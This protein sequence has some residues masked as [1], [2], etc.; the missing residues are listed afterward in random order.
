M[1]RKKNP[2]TNET[3]Q[4]NAEEVKSTSAGKS[5]KKTASKSSSSGKNRKKSVPKT[6]SGKAADQ[7]E[8]AAADVQAAAGQVKADVQDMAEQVK[9]D[10]QDMAEQ[11]KTDVQDAAEQVKTDVQ[12]AAEQTTT[13][14]QGEAAESEAEAKDEAAESEAEVKGEAAE[15]EAEA[16]DE[17]EEPEAEAKDET[18]EPEAEAKDETAEPEAEAQ[19]ETAEKQE[20]S[21]EPEADKEETAEKAAVNVKD[22]AR[23]L[24]TDVRDSVTQVGDDL[25]QIGDGIKAKGKEITDNAK[26][27]RKMFS[28]GVK[29]KTGQV[30]SGAVQF[31]ESAIGMSSDL[32]GLLTKEINEMKHREKRRSAEMISIFAKHNFYAG[33]FTPEEL[34]TTLEDLGPTYVKIGQIM[35]SRVDMLPESY[36]KELEKLRQNVKPLDSSVVRAI[37]EQETGKKIEEIYSFFDDNPLGSAS[38]GQ[39]HKATLLDGTQVVTKVQRP[40]IADMMRKDFVLLKKL[41]SVVK[42]INEGNEDQGEQIDLLAVLEELEKVEDEELDFRVEARNTIFFRENC[43]DDETKVTCPMIY[44]DLTTERMMTSTFIDGYSVSKKEKIAADGFDVNVIGEALLDNY[45]HQVLDVGVFHGDPHQGNIM[46]NRQ[47]VP[48]WIDFGMIGRLSEANIKMIQDLILSIIHLDTEALTNAALA[49]GAG[50]P[51]TNREKLTQDLDALIGKYMSVTNLKELDTAALLGEVMD[52]MSDNYISIP[53][54]YTMLVRSI[55]TIEGVMEE[56]CPDL[57]LFEII[58][59]KLLERAKKSFD[60]QQTLLSAGQDVLSVSKKASR[61]PSLA[62]DALNSVIKGRTK[63]KFELTGYEELMGRVTDTVKLAILAL[64]SCVVFFGSCILCLTDIQPTTA[65]GLPLMAVVGFIFS[66]A[67]GIYTVK[68]LSE[69]QKKQ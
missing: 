33:G 34:R 52:I 14:A 48:T 8:A 25:G 30:K 43:I 68:K 21:E 56:L 35:S 19:D 12:D 57:N 66:I 32:K 62:S 23:Q 7:A 11:V 41:A 2:N 54:E 42:T 36:C 58:T 20:K 61:I 53:G 28:N 69:Q 10:V 63:I 9:T 37:I 31:R 18:A 22:V 59:N 65:D 44:Q 51:K 64:F 17:A 6:A 49:M 24:K 4:N 38:I 16:K 13:D 26:A 67:L 50:G 1:A 60:L 40:L 15:S 5:G 3:P 27:R 45:V 29:E 47:G 55:A 39:V 46:I